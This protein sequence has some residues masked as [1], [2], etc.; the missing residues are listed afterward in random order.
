MLH[1][2][3]YSSC[4]PLATWYPVMV[5]IQ[6]FKGCGAEYSFLVLNV[7]CLAQAGYPVEEHQVTTSDGYV[8]LVARIPR[9]RS[10]QATFFVH[11]VFDTSL[12]WVCNGV[13]G[14]QAFAAWDAGFDVWLGTTRS[15]PPRLHLDPAFQ[16][17]SYW[18]YSVNEFGMQDMHAQVRTRHFI[19]KIKLACFLGTLILHMVFLII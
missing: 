4:I 2:H 8:L 19:F 16:G 17:A 11:G 6:T 1:K 15:N 5:V 3:P 13:T 14:S 18:N 9:P 7:V 10:R 12:C